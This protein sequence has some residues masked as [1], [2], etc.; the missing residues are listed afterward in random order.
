[1][2]VKVIV[3]ISSFDGSHQ[4]LLLLNEFDRGILVLLLHEGSLRD[5]V[6]LGPRRLL[7]L[8]TLLFFKSLVWKPPF[9]DAIIYAADN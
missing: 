3:Q 8:S 9:F 1:M 2:D 4:E 6:T 5:I 7:A